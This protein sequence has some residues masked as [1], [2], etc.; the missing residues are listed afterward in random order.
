MSH[1]QFHSLI[2]TFILNFV[3]TLSSAKSVSHN[4]SVLNITNTSVG[5]HVQIVGDL[6]NRFG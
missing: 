5:S 4:M 6:A 1:I 3:L 2:N